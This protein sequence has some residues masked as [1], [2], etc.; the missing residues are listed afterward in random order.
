MADV[1]AVD[2]VA[3]WVRWHSGQTCRRSDTIRVYVWSAARK[4]TTHDSAQ[5]PRASSNRGGTSSPQHT[6]LLSFQ[7]RHEHQ[8]QQGCPAD[9]EAGRGG[10]RRTGGG[11]ESVCGAE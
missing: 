4:D 7:P 6:T 11:E 9:G 5:K 3:G 2:V 10:A 8:Q 1:V